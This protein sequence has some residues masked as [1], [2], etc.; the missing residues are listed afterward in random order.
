MTGRIKKA[1]LQVV[2]EGTEEVPVAAADG[3]SEASRPKR[4][5]HAARVASLEEERRRRN[6]PE[7]KA[8]RLKSRR[9]RRSD[10]WVR[11]AKAKRGHR[12]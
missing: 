9:E 5:N 3:A 11:R 12:A 1:M 10:K 2:Q 8:E 6:E 7:R 4:H